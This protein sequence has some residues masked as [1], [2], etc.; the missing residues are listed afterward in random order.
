MIALMKQLLEFATLDAERPRL[1]RCEPDSL[2][3]ESAAFGREIAERKGR[4][5]NEWLT[6]RKLLGEQLPRLFRSAR[7]AAPLLRFSMPPQGGDGLNQVLVPEP[8]EMSRNAFG[9]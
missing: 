2:F 7:C 9:S 3:H 6:R 1:E 8:I 5:G 4:T